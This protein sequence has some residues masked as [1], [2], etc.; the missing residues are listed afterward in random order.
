MDGY[1]HKIPYQIFPDPEF[2]KD[3][4]V[5]TKDKNGGLVLKLTGA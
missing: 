2:D 5:L 4:M 1:R 3:N